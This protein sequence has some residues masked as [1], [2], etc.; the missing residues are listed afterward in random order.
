MDFW[1]SL[2]AGFMPHGFCLRWDA[3]LLFVFIAG[4]AGIALAYFLIPAA[5]R[6]FVGRR[7]DLP[8]PYMFRLFAAFI[9]SCGITHLA[10]IWT[11]YQPVYWI[12]AALD[13]WTAGVSLITAALLLPLLPQALALRSPAELQAANEKLRKTQSL[14][15]SFMNHSPAVVFMKNAAGEFVY[16]NETCAELFGIKVGQKLTWISEEEQETIAEQDAKVLQSATVLRM[17]ETVPTIEGDVRNWLTIKFPVEDVGTERLIGGVAIDITERKRAEE[18]LAALNAELQSARDQAIEM[19]NLKSAFIANMSHELRTPLSAILGLNELILQSELTEDQKV[20]STT[21]QESAQA[22][23][24]L[25]NDMLDL[26]KIEAG[27]M[28]IESIPFKPVDLID[29]ALKMVS[30]AASSKGLSLEKIVEPHVPDTV[31]GDPIKLGQVLLNLV[32]NAVKFTP[33]GAVIVRVRVEHSEPEQLL[34]FEV[35]DTGIGI[36]S[37]DRRFLFKP[38]SQVDSSSSR[39]YGGTGLGLAISKRLIELMGGEID[40]ESEPG[41]GSTFWFT[42]PLRRGIESVS[43]LSHTDGR[44]ASPSSVLVV[45]DHPVVQVLVKKQFE[46]LQ[47]ECSIVASA[48]EALTFLK[49]NP[50]RYGLVLMDCHLPGMDGLTATKV[51]RES[52]ADSDRRIPIIAMTAGAMK[53]DPEKCLAAGMDD[54]LAKPYT[55]DQLKEKLARWL[56]LGQ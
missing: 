39:K 20:Y 55:F 38:F 19:S 31:Y 6:Y 43:T 16:T 52:E 26:S 4:N 11:I 41:R 42:L 25:V 35:H 28:T 56:P 50:T 54:Y 3:P 23:L 51:I 37:A 53:G 47:L 18:S 46:M 12:E 22:L 34:K 15:D 10:K 33:S 21:V 14:F 36:S 17:E 8:Y 1:K 2:T 44:L 49:A 13:L 40:V 30:V 24:A 32:G 27:K 9:L 5:L 45:E 7:K 48:E 29:E